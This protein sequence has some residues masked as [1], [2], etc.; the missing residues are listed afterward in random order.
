MNGCRK[1]IKRFYACNKAGLCV[2]RE[3]AHECVRKCAVT[4][5]FYEVCCGDPLFDDV[6]QFCEECCVWKGY[7]W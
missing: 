3:R 2:C 5:E 4:L 7:I 1:T 6:A